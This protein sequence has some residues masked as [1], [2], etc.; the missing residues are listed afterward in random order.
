LLAVSAEN[1][2]EAADLFR[3]ILSSKGHVGGKIGA[4][5]AATRL[6]KLEMVSGNA[7]ESGRMLAEIYAS[8]TEGFE[9]I[10]LQQA[11]AVLDEWQE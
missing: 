7:V 4:L 5:Q 2:S 8:F 11:K 10:D 3:T 9:T 1:F 6:C